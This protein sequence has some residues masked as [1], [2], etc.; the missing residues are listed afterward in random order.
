MYALTYIN[1]VSYNSHKPKG[2]FI[3]MEFNLHTYHLR[4]FNNSTKKTTV[5]PMRKLLSYH[6]C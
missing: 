4:N 1:D 3:P 2:H 6:L 5:G